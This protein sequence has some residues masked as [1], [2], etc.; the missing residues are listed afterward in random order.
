MTKDPPWKKLIPV[1]LQDRSKWF[2]LISWAI[3][4]QKM[5]A[6]LIQWNYWLAFNSYVS[7]VLSNYKWPF[8][9]QRANQFFSQDFVRSLFCLVASSVASCWP[10]CCRWIPGF[11]L[12]FSWLIAENHPETLNVAWGS[13]E[14]S[15]FHTWHV[16]KSPC[17]AKPSLQ[18]SRSFAML[19]FVFLSHIYIITYIYINIIIYIYLQHTGV[20]FSCIATW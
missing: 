6:K 19:L 14:H 13:G 20:Y 2:Q 18:V 11:C 7:L 10:V 16:W 9:L 1:S 17:C 4:Y 15:I 3:D 12:W 5:L 8:I